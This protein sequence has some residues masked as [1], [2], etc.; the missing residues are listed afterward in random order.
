LSRT[1]RSK[2]TTVS[3]RDGGVCHYCREPVELDDGTVDHVVP[4]TRGGWD[5]NWN[6]VWCCLDCNAAKGAS[7]PVC[8]CGFCIHA[9]HEWLRLGRRPNFRAPPLTYSIG[10]VISAGDG[11]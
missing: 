1:R 10:D 2:R 4:E 7:M 11:C 3:D 5:A 8:G 9:V 6:L